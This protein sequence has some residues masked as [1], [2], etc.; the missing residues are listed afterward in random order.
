[1]LITDRY[2]LH[3][4]ICLH[5]DILGFIYCCIFSINI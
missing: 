4:L 3:I 5:T 2:K 1:M